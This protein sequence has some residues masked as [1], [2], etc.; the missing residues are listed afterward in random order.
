LKTVIRHLFRLVLFF[1]F[2][3]PCFAQFTE[4][5]QLSADML[6]KTLYAKSID[7]LRFCDYVIQKRDDGTIP[8][9]IIVGVYRKALTKDRG[10][11]LTYFRTALE[12]LCKQ[13]GIILYPASTK[14][15]SPLL[16]MPSL[17]MPSLN[18]ASQ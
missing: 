2:A 13:E 5:S 6:K 15:S 4:S 16:K 14:T 11:R 10:R 8:A 17:T 18:N 9:R 7:E 12:I 1:V 3:A